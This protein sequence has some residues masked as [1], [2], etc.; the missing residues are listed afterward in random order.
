MWKYRVKKAKFTYKKSG[1]EF[2]IEGYIVG[3]THNVHNPPFKYPL[4][5]CRII[6]TNGSLFSIELLDN[7][8]YSISRWEEYMGSRY[9]NTPGW[10]Q[11]Y[12]IND[13]KVDI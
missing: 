13:C 5:S 12:C 9:G 8:I 1:T 11:I 10:L 4:L 6:T 7:I 3:I 2:T